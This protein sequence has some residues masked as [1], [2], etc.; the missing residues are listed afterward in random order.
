MASST[1][2]PLVSAIGPVI[3][4][5]R[6][7]LLDLVAAGPEALADVGKAPWRDVGSRVLASLGIDGPSRPSTT[8][9]S[10]VLGLVG[11]LVV[12]MAGWG[13]RIWG[14]GGGGAGRLSPPGTTTYPPQISDDDYSYLT[15]AD[16]V[17]PPPDDPHLVTDDRIKLRYRSSVISIS[18][19]PY[20]ID[21][22]LLKI[23]DLRA[24]AAQ[25]LQVQDPTR[26]KLLYKG[27]I[28]K[29]D[30]RPCRDEGLKIDSEV[31]CMCSGDSPEPALRRR[32]EPI[33]RET[34]EKIETGPEPV[35]TKTKNKT[36]LNRRRKGKG[37]PQLDR[38]DH[39]ISNPNREPY[40]GR[41]D[42]P[43]RSS[44]PNSPAAAPPKTAREKLDELSSHFDTKLLPQ[45]VQ[46]KDA[47]PTDPAKREFEHRKLSET[48]LSEFML[49][50]DAIETDGNE[51]IR[52]RRRDLVRRAQ[53]VL[54]ELDA[55]VKDRGP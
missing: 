43:S 2:Q 5:L 15:T 34:G 18:F 12:S 42:G 40:H 46:F 39:S 21:D 50:L 1:L 53:G 35:P 26:L 20:S 19:P 45:S 54:A 10:I 37:P 30:L 31:L 29:D 22:G 55:V 13:E 49:K 16:L 7:R 23:A 44:T 52:Q 33:E 9:V 27:R 24:A 25:M 36:R 32:G 41:S 11:L 51:D 3:D 6:S 28:L 38:G 8:L 48:I 14:G 4:D 47:P 17:P